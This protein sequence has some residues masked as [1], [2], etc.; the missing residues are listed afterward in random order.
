MAIVHYPDSI[1]MNWGF[2]MIDHPRNILFALDQIASNP[3]EGLEGVICCG[4]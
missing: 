2:E 1:A 4:G 3:P